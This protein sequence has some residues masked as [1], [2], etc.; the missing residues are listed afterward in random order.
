MLAS[1]DKKDLLQDLK[2]DDVQRQVTW[3]WNTT[4]QIQRQAKMF[5]EFES[6]LLT[7]MKNDMITFHYHSYGVSLEDYQQ[8]PSL[9][10]F[11]KLLSTDVAEN[12]VTY[13]TGLQSNNFP[14]YALMYHPEYQVMDFESE[15]TF[16]VVKN[17]QTIDIFEHLGEFIYKEALRNR[18][19]NQPLYEAEAKYREEISLENENDLWGSISTLKFGSDIVI[20][21]YAVPPFNSTMYLIE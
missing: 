17:Q 11:F 14:I 1:N 21:A 8:I 12:G 5:S 15:H 3:Q 16:N 10:N 9:N 6:S 18:I 2:R 4:D 13:I 19:H 20:H 7:H